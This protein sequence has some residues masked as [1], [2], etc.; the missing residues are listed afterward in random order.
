MP[1]PP[2]GLPRH[3]HLA[4]PLLLTRGAYGW[5]WS[6]L[7]LVGVGTF[8]A[9]ATATGFV[10]CRYAGRPGARRAA[11]IL[12]PY[13]FGG[14]VGSAV[15]GQV[16]DRFGWPACVGGVAA[17]LGMA[18]LLAPAPRPCASVRKVTRRAAHKT[19]YLERLFTPP[20]ESCLLG[21]YRRSRSEGPSIPQRTGPLSLSTAAI[22]YGGIV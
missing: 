5:Y 13:F 11:S 19:G 21:P 10:G 6:V 8:F 20:A 22:F 4:L 18:A 2:S 7:A 1:G 3:G 14:L 17:A 9:Q 16:F 15:L 12:P